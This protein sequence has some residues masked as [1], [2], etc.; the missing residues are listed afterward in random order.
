MHT[1]RQQPADTKN[2]WQ[3]MWPPIGEDQSTPEPRSART[4]AE[5][6][7]RQTKPTLCAQPARVAAPA[8]ATCA[9]TVSP[10]CRNTQHRN[11]QLDRNKNRVAMSTHNASQLRA[12][13]LRL[14][15]RF[16]RSEERRVGKECRS[17]WS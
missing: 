2:N 8:C 1:V 15:G 11:E 12:R 4:I 13:V 16:P 10:N 6:I 9:R 17:R 5:Y 14:L 7:H 3:R